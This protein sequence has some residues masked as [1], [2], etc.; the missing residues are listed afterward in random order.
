MRRHRTK[1]CFTRPVMACRSAAFLLCLYAMPGSAKDKN[2]TYPEGGKIIAT[3]INQVP[4]TQTSTGPNGAVYSHRVVVAT[5]TYTVQTITRTYV[6][7]CAKTPHIFSRTPGECGG[8]KKL[9]IGD[10]IH[11][12]IEKNKAYI[13]APEA[14]NPELEQRLFILNEDLNNAGETQEQ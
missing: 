7:D 5:R 12:R 1:P 8:D 9:Q 2:R 10:E 11:F 13:P 4:R 3:G 14:A 6:L